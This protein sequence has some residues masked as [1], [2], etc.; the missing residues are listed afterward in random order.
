MPTEQVLGDVDTLLAAQ[1]GERLGEPCRGRE[2]DPALHQ[3]LSALAVPGLLSQLADE[4]FVAVTHTVTAA[5]GLR[6]VL[7]RFVT[8]LLM[9]EREF[10]AAVQ[11]RDPPDPD[12]S[13]PVRPTGFG[14]SSPTPGHRSD[15]CCPSTR[16]RLAVLGEPVSAGDW[17]GCATCA[18]P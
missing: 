15:G 4:G 18:T 6:G 7:A 1:P 9:A 14:S 2:F 11:R 3:A 13:W 16:W 12:P 10:D 5:P 17:P 8:A